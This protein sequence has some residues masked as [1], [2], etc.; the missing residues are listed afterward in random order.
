MATIA[1]LHDPYAVHVDGLDAL[2]GNWNLGGYNLTNGGAITGT[3][4]VI[5]GNTLTTSE[6][7]FLDGQD[8]G[9]KTSDNVGF[10]TITGTTF[11]SV[12]ISGPSP[13]SILFAPSDGLSA[14]ELKYTNGGIFPGWSLSNPVIDGIVLSLTATCIL[15][16]DLQQSAD[17]TH[18][19]GTFTGDVDVT[20]DLTADTDTLVVDVVNHYV[21]IRV[22]SP[23]YGFDVISTDGLFRLGSTH[24]DNTS[25][26]GRLFI[27]HYDIDEEPL[28]IFGASSQNAI[29]TIAFGGGSALGNAATQI[30]FFTAANTTTT[31][32]MSRVCIDSSGNVGIGAAT[33]A[34]HLHIFGGSTQRVEVECSGINPATYKM[35]NSEGSF[36]VYTNDD[37]F[38]I[39]DYSDTAIRVTVDG[40]GNV[41]IN[42]AAPGKKFDVGGDINV[43][44]GSVYYLNDV[45]VVGAQ[46]AHIADADAGIAAAAGDPPTQAEFNALVT[47][48]NDLATKFNMLL[49][50]LDA[51]A[52][53]GLLAGAP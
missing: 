4:F 36:A 30:D 50:H 35:T 23:E 6:W 3:S 22:A 38:Y 40:D 52:G 32:G 12:G 43:H 14:S 9:V 46:E 53:H 17:V 42:D 8:Q 28:Y 24:T 1:P 45:Q 25:K 27:P 13:L 10:G 33:V 18:N 7:A 39:Y 41:G 26:F 19:D 29:S 49:A 47:A 44:G 2:E 15:D 5:G 16:Q 11:N 51:D 20:G 34:E 31:T 37:N 48:Y 21:G